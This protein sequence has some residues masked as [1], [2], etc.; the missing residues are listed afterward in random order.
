MHRDLVRELH[1][2]GGGLLTEPLDDEAS[3]IHVSNNH[4]TNVISD[5]ENVGHRGWHNE[6]VG[7]LLLGADND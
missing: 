5:V 1:F 7:D 4:C 2:E 6:G 3:V